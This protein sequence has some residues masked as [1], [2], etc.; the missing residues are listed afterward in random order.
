MIG[1]HF[2]T[3]LYVCGAVTIVAGLG[4]AVAPIW[5]L[6]FQGMDLSGSLASLLTRHWGVLVVCFGGLLVWAGADSSM[7]DAVVTVVLVEKIA[8]IALILSQFG[9]PS[10]PK[11]LPAAIL[12]IAMSAA[13]F[14][15]LVGS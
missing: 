3:V 10:F 15:G 7:R 2:D 4:P 11:L 1:D 13:L 6:R 9:K 8:L 5:W 12:D 14:L